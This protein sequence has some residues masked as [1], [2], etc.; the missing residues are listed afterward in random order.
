M[1]Q[2][3]EM[4]DHDKTAMRLLGLADAAACAQLHDQSFDR[5]W[6]HESFARL[7]PQDGVFGYCF[8]VAKMSGFILCRLVAEE[9]E[10]LTIAVA[11]EYRQRGL[12]RRLV[13]AA[14]EYCLEN[15]VKELFLEVA[16]QNEPALALYRQLGFYFIGKRPKYYG[17]QAGLTMR[18]S[19]GA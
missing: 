3:T 17:D 14:Q 11:P 18:L 2:L 6:S 12:G 15:G 7:L 19:L 4:V 10:I 16:E 1:L 5:P 9:A 8:G 13:L